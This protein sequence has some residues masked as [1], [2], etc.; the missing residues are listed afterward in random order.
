MFGR[1]LNFVGRTGHRNGSTL[2]VRNDFSK[3]LHHVVDRVGQFGE[4]FSSTFIDF[5]FARQVSVSDRRNLSFQRVDGAFQCFP[6]VLRLNQ[7]HGVV[8]HRVQSRSNLTKFI[9]RDHF[10]TSIEDADADLAKHVLDRVGL[11]RERPSEEV[12]DECHDAGRTN[13]QQ[14]NCPEHRVDRLTNF[15]KVDFRHQCPGDV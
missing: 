4:G 8:A 7:R 5:N 3:L 12:R 10:T 14:Q 6:L 2:H 15:S 11:L 13:G 1:A 9:L